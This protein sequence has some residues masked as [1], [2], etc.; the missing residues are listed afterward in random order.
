MNTSA[1]SL[2]SL[3]CPR[4][5]WWCWSPPPSRCPWQPP[6]L[7]S[8][9]TRT[10]SVTLAAPPV[11]SGAS[12][13]WCHSLSPGSSNNS[14]A[15]KETKF[16]FKI[17]F[18]FCSDRD[19]TGQ[20]VIL[21]DMEEWACVSHYIDDRYQLSARKYAIGLK[22]EE[23]YEGIYQWQY[24]DGSTELPDYTVWASNHPRDLPCVSMQIGTGADR[25]G[26]W[27]DGDC[28]EENLYAICERQKHH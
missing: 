11:W 26:A 2:Q 22:S 7:I 21:E 16:Y 17:F 3:R 1:Q 5:T 23:H 4:C 18:S 19:G 13:T 12:T 6:G 28:V 8:V 15:S 14:T 10:P 25:N 27:M 9:T 20:L 24:R